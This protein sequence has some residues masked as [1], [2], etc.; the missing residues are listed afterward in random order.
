MD[1]VV[2]S[3]DPTLVIGIKNRPRFYFMMQPET[4]KPFGHC[5]PTL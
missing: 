2:V 1:F 5:N 3:R 4:S